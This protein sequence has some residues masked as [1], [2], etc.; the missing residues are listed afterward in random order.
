MIESWQKDRRLAEKKLN[1]VWANS[2]QDETLFLICIDLGE[3]DYVYHIIPSSFYKKPEWHDA[4]FIR[5]IGS[6]SRG[7]SWIRK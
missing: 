6:D 2:G 5:S 4:K 3:L 7:V 1:E